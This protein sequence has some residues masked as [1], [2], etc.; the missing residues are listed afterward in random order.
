VEFKSEVRVIKL[1]SDI[2]K[3]RPWDTDKRRLC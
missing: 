1:L 2:H 3:N